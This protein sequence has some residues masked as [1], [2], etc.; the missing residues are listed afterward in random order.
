MND[1]NVEDLNGA[2]A[3]KN[4]LVRFII[5]YDIPEMSCKELRAAIVNMPTELGSLSEY[6]LALAI[7]ISSA[8]H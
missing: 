2:Y 3:V 7:S 1:A 5:G 4:S 8:D 6:D